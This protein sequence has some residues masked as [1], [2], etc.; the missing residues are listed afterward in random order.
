MR[1]TDRVSGEVGDGK[2]KKRRPDLL[3]QIWTKNP[4]DKGA[5]SMK[6][7]Y[8]GL[9]GHSKNC[10]FVVLNARGRVIQKPP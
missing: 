4:N 8:I 5:A 7:Y 1:I 6:K 9:D 2:M 10:F 3:E